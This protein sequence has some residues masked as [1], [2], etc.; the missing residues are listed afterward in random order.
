MFISAHYA[1]TL[2]VHL[3]LSMLVTGAIRFCGYC[4]K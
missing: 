1:L 3:V 4:P 2:L